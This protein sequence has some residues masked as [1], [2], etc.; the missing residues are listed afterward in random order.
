[1][2]SRRG[3]LPA[4]RRRENPRRSPIRRCQAFERAHL[5][6]G[7]HL[8]AAEGEVSGCTTLPPSLADPSSRRRALSGRP[9]RHE[10]VRAAM[11]A[12]TPGAEPISAGRPHVRGIRSLPTSGPQLGLNAFR[13]C[14]TSP[15]APAYLARLRPSERHLR[16]SA[17][18][19]SSSG[20]SRLATIAARTSCCCCFVPRLPPSMLVLYI[21]RLIRSFRPRCACRSPLGLCT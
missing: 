18:R 2:P 11:A 3:A 14:R 7:K 9:R 13:P 12:P 16:P 5:S 1:V 20:S 6:R 8:D 17:L 15:I 4:S 21:P 10:A 19:S